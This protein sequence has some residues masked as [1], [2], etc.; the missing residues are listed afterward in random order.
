[1]L[2]SWDGGDKGVWRQSWPQS[3]GRHIH[4]QL[5]VLEKIHSKDVELHISKEEGQV[6]QGP[7]K[8]TVSR[9]SP[10]HKIR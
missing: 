10:Q 2:R 9:R 1:M 5:E 7:L 4:Q 3:V 8:V 6:Q